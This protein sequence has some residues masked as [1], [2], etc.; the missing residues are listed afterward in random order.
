MTLSGKHILLIISGG[1]AAY[2]SLDLIRRLKERGAKV[3]PVM[4]KGA[5]E[6]VTPLAV[7]VLS[8]THVFTELFPDRTSRMSAISGWRVT[9]TS[10]WW[11]PPLP[12]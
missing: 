12:I 8:A 9:A 10:C 1:I 2:K 11:R 7:G 3:T 4:T 5:Q 6:F